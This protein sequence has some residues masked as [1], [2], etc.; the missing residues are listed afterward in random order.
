[1]TRN[2]ITA[3][4]FTLSIALPAE[5]EQFAVQLD[6]AYDGAS[7][8]L[9]ETL[10][11]SEIAHFSDNGAHYIVLDAPSDAYIEAFVL[12]IAREAISLHVLEA[13][14]SNPVMEDLS[15]AQR[16]GFLRRITCEYCTS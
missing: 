16:L 8:K 12:A 10:R 6:A 4:A 7:A 15:M 1:M 11:V 13:N 14:W 9:M 5:A 3:C 2:L